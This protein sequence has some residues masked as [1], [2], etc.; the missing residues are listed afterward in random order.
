MTTRVSWTCLLLIFLAEVACERAAEQPSLGRTRQGLNDGGSVDGAAEDGGLGEALPPERLLRRVQLSLLGRPPTDDELDQMT[1]AAS[2]GQTE[3]FITERIDAALASPDFYEQLVLFG[4]DW[5]GVG[6]ADAQTNPSH[7]YFWGHHAIEMV[8][9]PSTTK[10]AGAIGLL[11]S[12]IANGDPPSICDDV[13][14]PIAQV[15]PWWAAGTTVTVIGRAIN[16]EKTNGVYQCGQANSGGRT[17]LVVDS[18]T[19]PKCGCGPHAV[20]CIP[21]R[22]IWR[23]NSWTYGWDNSDSPGSPNPSGYRIKAE[24][25]AR[26]FAHI[27]WYD[28]ALS[29]LVVGNY[30]VAPLSLRQMYVRMGRPFKAA[31]ALDDAR[32]FDPSTYQTSPSDPLHTPG[33]EFAWHE[34]VP[35]TL[36]PSLLSLSP[37]NTVLTGAAALQRSYTF[38]PRVEQGEPKGLPFAGILTT[39]VGEDSFPRER[40][41]AARWLE[42]L[43]CRSFIPPPPSL[44]FNEFKRDPA[45][46]GGCQHCHALIDPVAI[47]FKRW[48]FGDGTVVLAGMG[49]Y[50]TALNTPKLN[51]DPWRRWAATF[52]PST[53]MTPV[54]QAQLSQNPDARYLD[55]LPPDQHLFGATSDGTIGPLGFGKLLV[56]SGEFDR[57]AVRRI[58]QRFVGP[59]LTEDQ[60]SA[61]I[62]SLVAQ[63]LANDRKLRPFIRSLTQRP[64]YRRGL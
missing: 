30:T 5:F 37:N 42:S 19:S 58:Y 49:P 2:S 59:A 15:E 7:G 55:F 50:R 31:V 6:S 27:G 8:A 24:E 3:Q 63:F 18:P 41:R 26:L 62:D 10:H 25:V 9:C 43:A 46:E 16:T 1:A 40:V 13:N 60:N 54:T 39:Q 61:V 14:A 22:G 28:R 33:T 23:A 29:D 38:D 20:W 53:M 44:S 51:G 4:H 34:V 32:W 45:T 47:H 17:T 56:N 52:Q 57:C 48:G 35:E 21:P 36:N 64:E 12:Y 11:E